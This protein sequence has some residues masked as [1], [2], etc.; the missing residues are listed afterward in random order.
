MLSPLLS[1]SCIILFCYS[2]INIMI[3]Y[4]YCRGC[5]KAECG[6]MCPICS[7]PIWSKDLL[8]NFQLAN[9]LML[10][11]HMKSLIADGKLFCE[12]CF[13]NIAGLVLTFVVDST[14]IVKEEN[15]REI[16]D[17]L[18]M[19]RKRHTVLTP[20]TVV[21][22]EANE[23]I[24][25]TDNRLKSTI[26]NSP[27]KQTKFMDDVMKD[28][29]NSDQSLTC[30]TN[31]IKNPPDLNQPRRKRRR[32]LSS[33]IYKTLKEPDAKFPFSPIYKRTRSFHKKLL[34]TSSLAI[35]QKSSVQDREKG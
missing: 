8:P 10:V 1:V 28:G 22:N 27:L 20:D 29:S 35:R 9:V 26:I 32:V 24:L 2:K 23:N 21:S 14:P 7:I 6:L 31:K 13:M 3:I 17:G 15:V 12:D 33:D 5:I 19:D 34:P 4:Y 16:D 30:L 11:Q 18:Q 25:P